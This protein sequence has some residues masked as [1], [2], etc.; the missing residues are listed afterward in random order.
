MK[1]VATKTFTNPILLNDDFSDGVV[2]TDIYS[3]IGSAT[4]S[5]SGG[6]LHVTTYNTGDGLEILAPEGAVDFLA[7]IEINHDEFD[8]REG[9]VFATEFANPDTDESLSDFEITMLRPF[10]NFC[11]YLIKQPGGGAQVIK[12]RCG[13]GTATKDNCPKAKDVR[14]TWLPPDPKVDPKKDRL[15]YEIRGKD[16]KWKAGNTRLSELIHEKN[17]IIKYKITFVGLDERWRYICPDTKPKRTGSGVGK[18]GF[19]FELDNILI[20]A[21]PPID[22][23]TPVEISPK[24]LEAGAMNQKVVLHAVEENLFSG[25]NLVV[26]FGPGVLLKDLI[27]QDTFTAV[28]HV[29]VSPRAPSG[30]HAIAAESTDFRR[31]SWFDIEGPAVPMLEYQY[32]GFE[33]EIPTENTMPV[34]SLEVPIEIPPEPEVGFN[35]TLNFA[36]ADGDFVEVFAAVKDLSTDEIIFRSDRKVF[37]TG[38]FDGE[39]V[40]HIVAVPGLPAGN[41]KLIGVVDDG[42]GLTVDVRQ[43]FQ[44]GK[45]Q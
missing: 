38:L 29:D 24:V 4:L 32:Y 42:I 17:K 45:L 1:E 12:I 2:N 39:P 25:P 36:D 22:M 3:A 43:E 19:K 11:Q 18:C 23:S 44:V 21:L 28:A 5:E 13:K 40:Q 41:Y 33:P 16:G 9:L 20:S 26:S 7:S 30:C 37:N 34:L 31:L 10:W 8:V 6:K 35:V 27:V 15:R 14:V